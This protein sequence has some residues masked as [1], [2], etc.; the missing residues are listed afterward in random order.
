MSA[1]PGATS[2]FPN[3]VFVRLQEEAA[4][5]KPAVQAD[6]TSAGISTVCAQAAGGFLDGDQSRMQV[7]D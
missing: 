6:A 4:E 2:A 7:I 5:Q 1:Q 3:G